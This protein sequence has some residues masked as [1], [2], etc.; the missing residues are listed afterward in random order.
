MYGPAFIVG[1]RGLKRSFSN[2]L[3]VCMFLENVKIVLYIVK[4][5]KNIKYIQKSS[6]ISYIFITYCCNSSLLE[7]S[8][9]SFSSITSFSSTADHS[10]PLRYADSV[11]L[12]QP[13]SWLCLLPP[14]C[15]LMILSVIVLIWKPIGWEGFRAMFIFVSKSSLWCLWSLWEH[16]EI[17]AL[18]STEH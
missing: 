1:S 13:A 15:H 5:L 11:Y 7:V 16:Q 6:K 12:A 3:Q 9:S 17:S 4:I 8:F 14:L 10:S 2:D 18:S